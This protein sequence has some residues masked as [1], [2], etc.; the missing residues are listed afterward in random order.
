M[1]DDEAGV[2]PVHGAL[3][4]ALRY[5]PSN[6]VSIVLVS[7]LWTLASLPVITVGPATLGVYAAVRSLREEGRVDRAFV[8]AT[9]RE[10][11]LDALLLGGVALVTSTVSLLYFSQFVRT[12]ST[13]AGVLGFAG[14]YV[15][16]HYAL[17]LVPTFVALVDGAALS[18][19]VRTGYRWTVTEPFR[20][21]SMLILTG[22]LLAGS[23][24]LTVAVVLVFP[25]V[26]AAFHTEL[27][28][29]VVEPPS[30]P[31]PAGES[32][33]AAADYSGPRD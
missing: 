18:G 1:T 19:A 3:W 26:A 33:P 22:L 28:V 30:E 29:P 8:L 32:R 23:A 6:A 14:V 7:V 16:L 17:V 2:A 4:S 12:G 21:V 11:G 13:V 24:L 27:L 20:A 5:L 10:H 9:V 31:T 15:T 25:A